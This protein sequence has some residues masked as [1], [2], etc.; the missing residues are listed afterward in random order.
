MDLNDFCFILLLLFIQYTY[1]CIIREL[2]SSDLTATLICIPVK[3]N[4]R[5]LHAA[6]FSAIFC[7]SPPIAVIPDT[8]Y[9]FPSAYP[10]SPGDGACPSCH[11]ARG[12]LHPGRVISLFIAGLTERDGQ[13]LTLTFTPSLQFRINSYPNTHVLDC[14]KRLGY[15]YRQ[16]EHANRKATSSQ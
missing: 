4:P 2:D 13:P 12:R 3:N 14:V 7:R 5:P 1:K 8:S 9:P 10:A 6:L 11:R 15:H 16:G